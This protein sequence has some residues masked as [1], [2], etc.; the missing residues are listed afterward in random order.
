MAK[1][2]EQINRIGDH[3]LVYFRRFVTEDKSGLDYEKIA[4][5]GFNE[6]QIENV[7]TGVEQ[8]KWFE[9]VG[10]EPKAARAKKKT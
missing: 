2:Q 3:A 6:A 9:K 5:A 1:E 7:K 10:E 4:A 8:S